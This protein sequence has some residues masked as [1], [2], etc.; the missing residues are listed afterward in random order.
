MRPTSLSSLVRAVLLSEAR[1]DPDSFLSYVLGSDPIRGGGSASESQG[2]IRFAAAMIK[3][4]SLGFAST[5]ALADIIVDKDL[6]KQEGQTVEDRIESVR[7]AWE[8]SLSEDQL[9]DLI[10]DLSERLRVTGSDEEEADGPSYEEE[11]EA[12]DD[13]GYPPWYND[14]SLL[15]AM[16]FIHY[17]YKL[18]GPTPNESDAARFRQPFLADVSDPYDAEK[19]AFKEYVR[20]RC[21]DAYE[22]YYG[23]SVPSPWR[24]WKPAEDESEDDK[25]Q[26][27]LGACADGYSDDYHSYWSRDYPRYRRPSW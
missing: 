21:P 2:R 18:P 24:I 6:F 17:S 19:F 26:Q 11:S 3:N 10:D 27:I 12:S 8:G 4:P 14:S 23:K 15:Q 22:F 9:R 5:K 13:G 16:R 25:Y 20:Q 1:N 7:A